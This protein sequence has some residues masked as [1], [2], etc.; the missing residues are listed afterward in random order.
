VAMEVNEIAAAQGP[1]S[2]TA[3]KRLPAYSTKNRFI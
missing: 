2:Q 3:P 1:A